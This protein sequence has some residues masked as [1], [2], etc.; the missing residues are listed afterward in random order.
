MKKRIRILAVYLLLLG[1]AGSAVYA[2]KSPGDNKKT[3]EATT[4]ESTIPEFETGK[5]KKKT[6]TATTEKTT[7]KKKD[8]T[9]ESTEKGKKPGKKTETG[10]EKTS[11]TEDTTGTGTEDPS[12]T[13]TE[14]ATTMSPYYTGAQIAALRAQYS[15]S[16]QEKQEVQKLLNDM[17]RKQNAFIENLQEMDNEIIRIQDQL[18][19][20]SEQKKKVDATIAQ[21]RYELEYAEQDVQ[22]QY[23][24]LKDHIQNSY[25]NG[26]FSYMD[27]LLQAVNFAD[28]LNKTEYV[29]QV[30]KY[31]E[32][33]L[34][35]YIAARQQLANRL[36][37]LETMTEDY[38]VMEQ[39]YKDRQ[40]AIVILSDEK[41]N[42][43]TAFQEQID[44]QQAELTKLQVQ[45]QMQANQIAEIERTA[46]S[47]ISYTPIKY[48]GG[49]FLW[50]Q[51]SSTRITSDYGYRGDIGVP[52]AS[53]YHQGI[54]IHANMY[55]PL[56]AAADGVVIYVGYY[57]TG[58]KTVMIDVGSGIT[59]IYHHLN[60]YSVTTGQQVTSGQIVGHVGM[61][62]VSSGPHLHF[63]VR[64][65]GQ[66]VDPKPYLGI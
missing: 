56:V 4:E 48:P 63:S 6:E 59:I 14:T 46:R 51:P 17:K 39:V 53:T 10:T 61:T 8:S 12:G 52:G 32:V 15:Q 43:I 62:G 13:S 57:G 2:A 18:D 5:K 33:L 40:D 65:N 23:S 9:E 31:D 30:S 44:E 42:Q 47:N 64:V 45:E 11:G 49:Q 20:M 36:K 35:D 29:E 60:D 25:E 58:G 28:V 50:P 55:D 54:D 66:Y 41:E 27:A 38:G 22:S 19:E 26:N 16:V 24:K 7:N 3:T 34:G 21:L 37:M 1:F